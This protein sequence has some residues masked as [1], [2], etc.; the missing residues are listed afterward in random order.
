VAS[1]ST[2]LLIPFIAGSQNNKEITFNSAID[3]LDEALCGNTSEAITATTF[4]LGST[5][6]LGNLFFKFTGTI[7]PSLGC[8]V[9]LPTG[10]AKL[11]IVLNDLT[12][13]NPM[14]FE[15]GTNVADVVISDSTPHLMYSDGVGNVYKI[16]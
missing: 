10:I 12:N 1:V 8:T 6:F 15:V 16:S 13:M 9:T 4:T 14:T 7:S 3:A 5:D 2:N 11:F